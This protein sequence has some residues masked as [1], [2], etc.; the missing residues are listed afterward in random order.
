M[1]QKVTARVKTHYAD[2][3][4]SV[5]GI[6]PGIQVPS[7]ISEHVTSHGPKV[8][9]NPKQKMWTRIERDQKQGCNTEAAMLPAKR[10]IVEDD[11]GNQGDHH[12]RKK[13]VLHKEG[14]NTSL[15]AKAVSKP[16]QVQ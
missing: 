11:E 2:P 16:R 4:S 9:K 7:Q 10:N 5:S 15:V 14:K 6:Q 3:V 13:G 1:A 8:G 12:K